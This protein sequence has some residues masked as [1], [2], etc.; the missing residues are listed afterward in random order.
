[1][2]GMVLL[3]AVVVDLTVTGRDAVIVILTVTAVVPLCAIGP[4]AQTTA[5]ALSYMACNAMHVSVLGM[6]PPAVICW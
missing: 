4:S 3:A 1:M 2:N 6:R 5:N